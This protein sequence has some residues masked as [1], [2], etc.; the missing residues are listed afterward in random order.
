[1][2]YVY[3]IQNFRGEDFYYGY[4]DNLIRRMKEHKREDKNCELIYYEAYRAEIDAR[5]REKKL[6]QYGQ[7]RTHLKNRITNSVIK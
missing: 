1:M 7:S 4:T 3:C 6:K 2:Y 5:R